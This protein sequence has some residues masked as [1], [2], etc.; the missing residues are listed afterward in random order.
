M[1]MEEHSKMLEMETKK[2]AFVA[3]LSRVLKKYEEFNVKSMTYL[4]N[5]E[6]HEEIVTVNFKDEKSF[7]KCNVT[8]D[9]LMAIMEDVIHQA[10]M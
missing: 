7:V 1:N 3:D 8:G 2:S 10:L 6:D 4:H 9:S 5:R